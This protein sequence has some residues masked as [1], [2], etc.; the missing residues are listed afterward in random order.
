MA[1]LP[2]VA[3]KSLKTGIWPYESPAP[4]HNLIV[5]VTHRMALELP[6]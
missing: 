1:N 5:L 6:K 2:G 3:A 4:F